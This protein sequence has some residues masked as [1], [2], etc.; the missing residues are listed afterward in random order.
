M[1]QRDRLRL[2]PT[3]PIMTLFEIQQAIERLAREERA[4]LRPW[5]LAR[6]DARG[7][8]RP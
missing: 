1:D 5:L 6:Y 7:Y 4:I 8:R 3:A 2:V